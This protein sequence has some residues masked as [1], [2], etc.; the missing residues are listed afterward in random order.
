MLKLKIIDTSI[1]LR[2]TVVRIKDEQT[3][4][5]LRATLR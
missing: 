5:K 2:G 1:G 3:V 4:L